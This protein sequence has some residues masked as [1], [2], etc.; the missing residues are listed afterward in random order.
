MATVGPRS[1]DRHRLTLYDLIPLIFPDHYLRGAGLRAFYSGRVELIRHVDG[2]LALSQHTADDAIE[3]LA[4]SPERVHVV[5]AGANEHFVAMYPS[6][7]EVGRTSRITCDPFT[8]GFCC[9]SE[10]PT[11]AR[12]RKG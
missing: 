10:A 8:R 12:T 3:R 4:V 2:V 9:T 11:F 5:H 7:T 1:C 6:S